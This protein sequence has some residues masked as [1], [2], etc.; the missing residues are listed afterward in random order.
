MK[1]A[2][3][4]AGLSGLALA[5]MLKD[6]AA[7]TLFEKARG[8][9]GRMSTRYADPYQF[10]HGAQ[11]FTVRT[12]EFAQFLQPFIT[13]NIVRH[14]SPQ[15]VKL[16]GNGHLVGIPQTEDYYISVPKMN[17]LCKTLAADK[18]VRIQ[19]QIAAIEKTQQGWML[20]DNQ[21]QSFGPYDIV[22]ST[23]PAPQTKALFPANFAYTNEISSSKL[24]GCYSLMLG[25]QSPPDIPWD[26]ARISNSPLSWIAINS[27]KEGRD[28]AF[29]LIAQTT[30]IWAEAHIDNDQE[31]VQ[32]LL[33]NE[34]LRQISLHSG[35]Y[36]PRTPDYQTLHRWRYA[37]TSIPAAH[38]YYYDTDLK[39]AVCGDWCIEGRVE[40]AFISA[41][42]FMTAILDQ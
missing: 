15:I 37:A 31:E 8:V 17:M 21:E 25:Y 14:W 6:K 5:E 36:A 11:Y 34:T 41:H 23:A 19:H 38:S 18:D 13:S 39:L 2:I 30:N 28:S 26:A 29:S 33:V 9:G 24:S 42:K 10:D 3:I 20:F 40:A 7:I 27:R 35:G 32:T 4:G 12:P 22:V 16:E 1:I